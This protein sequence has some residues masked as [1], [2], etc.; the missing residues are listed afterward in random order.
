L[1]G[2]DGLAGVRFDFSGGDQR[3]VAGVEGFGHRGKNRGSGGRRV[4]RPMVNY[5]VCKSVTPSR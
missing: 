4:A 1:P 2:Q 5:A 3:R